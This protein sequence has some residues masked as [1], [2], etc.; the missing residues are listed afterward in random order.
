MEILE[1]HGITGSSLCQLLNLFIVL[2]VNIHQMDYCSASNQISNYSSSEGC[3]CD[4]LVVKNLDC[5][6]LEANTIN[7]NNLT[8]DG[9][10]ISDDIT[11][12]ESKTQFQNANATTS[13]T[14]FTGTLSADTIKAS[15]GQVSVPAVVTNTIQP[16]GG[17]T[18][19]FNS[20]LAVTGTVTSGNFT[21][22]D[23]A[24]SGPSTTA[25]F[26]MPNL[27]T[28]ASTQILVGKDDT[29]TANSVEMGYY[30]D[31]VEA[32]SYGY[33]QLRNVSNSAVRVFS[34]YVHI[35][36]ELRIANNTASNII[37]PRTNG[38]LHNATSLAP[39]GQTLSWTIPSTKNIKRLIV[40]LNQFTKKP[41]T[42][43]LLL[44]TN[45]VS[46]YTGT[47]W[48]NQGNSSKIWTSDGVE[49][50][51]GPFP[52]AA[53]YSISGAIEITY[54]QYNNSRHTY[55]ING[56]LSCPHTSNPSATHY[57]SIISGI[58]QLPT[59]TELSSLRLTLPSGDTTVS[60]DLSGSMSVLYY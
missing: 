21:V 28:G 33:L 49:L 40:M 55:A 6:T 31:S 18:V 54:F 50:W 41:N 60:G 42:N 15:T 53:T 45:G 20:N 47:T 5:V 57:Y 12:L 22:T 14:T 48:G 59:A 3:C 23:P 10:L 1:L 44:S 56:Q 17:T 24:S 8:V 51:N 34:T 4:P 46:T 13:T 27:S 37:N 39:V 30:R 2:E 11:S 36:G 29:N 7:T 16:L 19:N 43:P 32:N 35:P 58:I 38:A 26:L 25:N 9:N 52:L